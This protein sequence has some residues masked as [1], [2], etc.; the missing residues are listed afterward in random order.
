MLTKLGVG[1]GAKQNRSKFFNTKRFDWVCTWQAVTSPVFAVRISF[2][3]W[4]IDV[5]LLSSLG[6]TTSCES[7]SWLVW[8][9]S[10]DSSVL[11][12]FRSLASD[13][14]SSR[15]LSI[16]NLRKVSQTK[17]V[18]IYAA[19]SSQKIEFVEKQSSPIKAWSYENMDKLDLWNQNCFF[20]QLS[21]KSRSWLLKQ[22]RA[23]LHLAHTN[24]AIILPEVLPDVLWGLQANWKIRVQRVLLSSIW[25][26]ALSMIS[27]SSQLSPK[28]FHK[29]QSI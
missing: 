25:P 13:W 18:L 26:S 6:L 11:A 16:K 21:R 8:A 14:K 3:D 10:S 17:S 23:Q 22:G 24:N 27:L 5:S 4:L 9:T 7:N 19:V 29:I 28:S 12:V 15:N 2:S 1:G 20:F